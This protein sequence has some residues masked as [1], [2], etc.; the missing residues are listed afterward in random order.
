MPSCGDGIF[1]ASITLLEVPVAFRCFVFVVVSLLVACPG[2]PPVEPPPA[3][4]GVVA[5]RVFKGV[6]KEAA[7]TVYRFDGLKRGAVAGTAATDADGAFRVPVGTSTGPLLVVAVGGSYVDEATGVTVQ[8]GSAELTALVPVFELETKLEQLRITPVSHLA[9]TLALFWAE[10]ESRTLVDA[11]AEAWTRLNRHFGNLDWRSVTPRDATASMGATLAD[12]AAKAGVLLGAL[13]M[14]ARLVSESAGL[15]PGGRVNPSTVVS[16]LADDLNADGFLDGVGTRGQLVLPLGGQVKPMPPTA[17]A[18]DGQTARTGLGQALARFVASDR[19]STAVTVAD[20]TALVQA[21]ATNNDV[22]LFRAASMEVDL[23][24]PV[25]AWVRPQANAGVRGVIDVEVTGADNRELRTL[26][27]TAPAALL[28]TTPVIAADKT[29]GRLTATLDVSSLMD[30]PL[31]LAARATDAAGNESTLR[32]TIIVSQRGPIITVAA[33]SAMASVR[34]VVAISASAA[35]QSAGAAITKLELRAPTAGVSPD[36]EASAAMLA[37]QWNTS[38]VTEGQLTLSFHAEDNQGG[39]S[40]LEVPVVVDNVALGTVNA[41]VSAGA[42]LAGATVKLLAVDATTGLPVS[43]RVGGPVL[44]E[45]VTDAQGVAAFTLA[46]ENYSG[47]VQLEATGS[48]LSVLDVSDPLPAL[49]GG[50]AAS[51]SM[52]GTF[53]LT[54]YVASYRAGDALTAHAT[55]YTTIADSAARAYAAGRVTGVSA[56]SLPTALPLSDALFVAHVSRPKTWQLRGVRP[57]PITVAGQQTLR[58]TVYA[59]LPDVALHQLARDLSVAGATT[60]GTAVTAFTLTEQLVR[61][62]GDGVFDGRAGMQQLTAVG[63]PAYSLDANTTRFKLASSLDRWVRGP[64]NLTSLTRP[65]MQADGVFDNLC[66][67]APPSNPFYPAATPPIPFDSSPPQVS[68]VVTFTNGTLVDSPPLA[69]GADQVVAGTVKVVATASDDSGMRSLIIRQAGTPL[70]ELVGNTPERWVG[71]HQPGSSAPVTYTAAACD[72][73][74]NC[75]TS[76][77]TL[78]ADVASPVITVTQPS[79][80]RVRTTV[81]V[82]ASATDSAGVASVVVSAGLSG[83]TDADASAGRVQGSWALPMV[84]VDGPITVTFRG[85]DV[86]GNCGTATGTVIIDRTPPVITTSVTFLNIGMMTPAMPLGA[87]RVVAGTITVVATATD[88]AGLASTTV[89]RM[90]TPLMPVMGNTVSRFQGSFVTTSQADGAL[91]IVANS[92]DTV[93][94]CADSN[95]SLVVDNTAPTIAVQ[96]PPSPSPFYSVSVPVEATASDANGALATAG[97]TTFSLNGWSGFADQ[98]AAVGRVF[99]AWTIIPSQSDGQATSLLVACDGVGNCTPARMLTA[100]IDRTPPTVTIT[101]GPPAFTNVAPNTPVQV[102]ATASDPG[103]GVNAAYLMLNVDA[104]GPGS[105]AVGTH[106]WLPALGANDGQRLFTVYAIDNAVPPN[107]GQGRPAPFTATRSTF[108]DR[109]PPQPIVEVYPAVLDE[110]GLGFAR[111]VANGPPVMPP[112]Y[113]YASTQRVDLSPGPTGNPPVPTT[114]A[115]APTRLSWGPSTPSGAELEAANAFNT[116][117]QRVRVP[118]N[119]AS[120]SPIVSASQ[121]VTARFAGGG[122]SVYAPIAAIASPTANVYLLPFAKENVPLL[123]AAWPPGVAGGP[124]T[125]IVRATFSAMDAAGNIGSFQPPEVRIQLATPPI[126]VVRDAQYATRGDA[127]SL[128]QYR[129]SNQTYP[130]LFDATNANFQADDF[131][132]H[133]RL[134]VYNPSTEPIALRFDFLTGAGQAS[135]D[136]VWNAVDYRIPG[137][138]LDLSVVDGFTFRLGNQWD[139]TGAF[140]AQCGFDPQFQFPCSTSGTQVP[141][142]FVGQTGVAV[143]CRDSSTVPGFSF[144]IGTSF[145]SLRANPNTRQNLVR[146]F[147]D[148]VMGPTGLESTPAAAIPDATYTQVVLPGATGVTAGTAAVYLGG[149][150]LVMNGRN[151]RPLNY[152]GNP[153]NATA[154]YQFWYADFWRYDGRSGYTCAPQFPDTATGWYRAWR[155]YDQLGTASTGVIGGTNVGITIGATGALQSGSTWT[156]FGA[157]NTA[158]TPSYSLFFNH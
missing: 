101:G 156:A 25:L 143:S 54:S 98:D 26:T 1:N 27:F 63:A 81:P 84:L 48:N 79:G 3:D 157:F 22:R 62:V 45:G 20:V 136:E 30:G 121:S 96:S 108:V 107:S 13:S 131:L 154:R 64:R 95:I 5:G 122:D 33:P 77:V 75:T 133:G 140:A 42:P 36:T 12:D 126:A 80:Q 135:T 151:A 55:L 138:D 114:V 23:D 72:A 66:N 19:N 10:A 89:T 9:A 69:I 92:C 97:V 61:D 132:R 147:R 58:D 111:T 57:A 47:P 128:Y 129:L 118:Y 53:A 40:D 112:V 127:K 109:T 152:G 15:T 67:S 34:G 145:N 52:P 110:T 134:I 56:M 78:L 146:V 37:V 123:G 120:D 137:N 87:S 124:P 31:E 51:V 4:L 21:L 32:R 11:D 141:V 17:T 130:Q 100:N 70:T 144:P 68:F 158:A 76:S 88:D 41:F 104:V 24:A 148:A 116:P 139:D 2:R 99:G 91:M 73:L 49:D 50:P 82:E 93:G 74:N 46:Q 142:H 44:G 90:G 94:N 18:V 43:G 150:R 155:W 14:Q 117:F 38:G 105:F 35:P 83:F 65:D 29:T 28:A 125:A 119:S 102:T 85:C 7:V 59:A 8:A 106:M 60:P 153:Y 113:T 16:A 86:V 6:V 71:T 149:R 103:A 115:K 39:V